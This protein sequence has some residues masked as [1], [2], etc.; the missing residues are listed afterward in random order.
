MR[1]IF[2]DNKVSVKTAAG[3]E[4]IGIYFRYAVRN[5]NVALKVFAPAERL[6]PYVKKIFGKNEFSVKTSAIFERRISDGCYAVRDNKITGEPFTAKYYTD[7][8]TEKYS[9]LYDL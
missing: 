6:F 9:D 3:L 2:P 5:D 1:N 4:G 8:L 7:Y